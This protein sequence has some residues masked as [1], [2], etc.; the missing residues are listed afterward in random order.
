[1]TDTAAAVIG[2]REFDFWLG[3]W[4]VT[5]GDNQRGRNK[6][7]AILDGAVILEQF[8][9]QA[10]SPLRG[11]SVSVYHPGRAEWR[12]TWVD[13][14]GSYWAFAGGFAEGRMTLGTDEVRSGQAV[15]LRMQWH[16]I[17]ANAFD[18]HWQR[19]EDGGQTWQVLWAIRYTRRA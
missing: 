6:V 11:M 1:M 14:Q 3:D 17:E 10:A 4:D 19:S 7:E 9:G 8:D 13:N 12:Q 18:W 16:N 2:A 5:W 15:K